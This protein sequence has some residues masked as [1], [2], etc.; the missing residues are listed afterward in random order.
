MEVADRITEQLRRYLR[1]RRSEAAYIGADYDALIARLEEFV[2]SGGKRLRPVF[3]YWGWR[4][5][6]TRQAGRKCCCCS[7]RWNCCTPAHW[8]MT[9]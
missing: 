6:A 7:R 5:V 1:E 4:A 2:L 9:T 8:C 3:A